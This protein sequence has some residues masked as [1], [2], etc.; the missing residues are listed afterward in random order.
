MT[1]LLKHGIDPKQQDEDGPGTYCICGAYM[2]WEDCDVCGGDGMRE[3]MD[4]PDEWGE[5]CPSEVN[6]L[7]TCRECDGRGGWWWCPDA[8]KAA[9]DAALK[10]PQR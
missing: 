5:D 2:E 10:E 3:C 1:D 7:I 9:T 8:V 6:H 4:A